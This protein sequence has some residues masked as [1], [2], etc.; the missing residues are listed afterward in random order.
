MDD[1]NLEKLTKELSE[2]FGKNEIEGIKI[3]NFKLRIDVL[4]Y[5]IIPEEPYFESSLS[6]GDYQKDLEKIGKKYGIENLSFI[7]YCYHK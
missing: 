6:G 2:F 5:K 3:K 7:H 4:D 1:K